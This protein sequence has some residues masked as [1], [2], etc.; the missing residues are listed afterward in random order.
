LLEP[1]A[2]GSSI[3]AAWLSPASLTN[4]T[5]GNPPLLVEIQCDVRLDGPQ[6]GTAGTPDLDKLS[7]NF[8]A[9]SDTA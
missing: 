5:G 1:R 7:A 2:S 6:V 3:A 4:I 9:G 8:L